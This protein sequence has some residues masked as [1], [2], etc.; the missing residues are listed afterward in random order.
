MES[1]GAKMNTTAVY[2]S[3]TIAYHW[4]SAILILILWLL[5]DNID[6]FTRGDPRV[7]ARSTHIA[8]G[9]V[10]AVI[11]ALR[12]KW[13]I[14][15]ATKLPQAV[16]GFL[17]KLAV[18]THHIFYLLIACVIAVGIAAVWVRWD[19][20]FNLFRVPAFDPANKQLREEVVDLHGLLV[21]VLLILAAGHSLLALWHHVMI[22]D[23]VLKRMWPNLK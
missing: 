23:G 1:Q 12:L 21:N 16:P 8:L 18:S 22:K 6:F 10:L 2:D 3:K 17:G 15:G 4:I 13:K 19:N 20:I 14:G 11:L 5:G 7:Y 9:L